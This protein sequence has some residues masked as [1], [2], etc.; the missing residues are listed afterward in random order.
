MIIHQNNK[1]QRNKNNNYVKWNIFSEPLRQK[2]LY[3]VTSLTKG[4]LD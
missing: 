2:L 3:Q 1:R 4:P